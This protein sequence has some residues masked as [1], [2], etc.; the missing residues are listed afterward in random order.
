MLPLASFF[1]EVEKIAGAGR[2]GREAIRKGI[3][4]IRQ[5]IHEAW[6]RKNPGRYSHRTGARVAAAVEKLRAVQGR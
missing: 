5:G 6:K 3:L 2:Y 4:K 1:D